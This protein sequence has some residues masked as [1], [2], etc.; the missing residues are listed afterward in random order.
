[1]N[2]TRKIAATFLAAVMA[3]MVVGAASPAEAARDTGWG[4]PGC[5][6]AK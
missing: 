4:C 1:M 3:S 6:I 5:R 2:F